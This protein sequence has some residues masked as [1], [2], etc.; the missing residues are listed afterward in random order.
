MLRII[1]IGAMET[2]KAGEAVRPL[3]FKRHDYY[4]RIRQYAA[5]WRDCFKSKAVLPRLVEDLQ[6][7]D[8]IVRCA[9]ARSLYDAD[10]LAAVQGLFKAMWDPDQDVRYW[11]VR[12]KP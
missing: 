6:H 4:L 7:P 1:A 8:A 12:G 2:I 10:D 5:V 11:A 3:F 9:V